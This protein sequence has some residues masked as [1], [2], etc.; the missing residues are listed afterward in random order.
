MSEI[1]MRKFLN[2]LW[3]FTGGKEDKDKFI[4]KAPKK[5]KASEKKMKKY[6]DFYEEE[7]QQHEKALQ[8]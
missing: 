7:K 6:K 4:Q 2:T 3:E 8:S 5:V 1:N